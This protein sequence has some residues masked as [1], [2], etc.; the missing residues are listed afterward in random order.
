MSRRNDSKA[1]ALVAAMLALALAGAV[2][3]A[4]ARRSAERALEANT[5][6]ESLRIRWASLSCQRTLLSRAEGVLAEEEEK[7]RQPTSWCRRRLRLGGGLGVELVFGDEQAK[8]SVN[9]LYRRRGRAG[10]TAAL[11]KLTSGRR[12]A[13]RVALE[14][15]RFQPMLKD[16]KDET[17]DAFICFGQL[18]DPCRLEAL[19]GEAG[20]RGGDSPPAAAKI[21]CWG[22]GTLSFRRASRAAMAEVA[23]GAISGVH[24]AKLLQLRRAEPKVSLE[25]ALGRI[26]LTDDQRA[27]ASK[28]LTDQS[29]C[30][31]M[32]IV[33]DTGRRR[34]YRLAVADTASGQAAAV[35]VKTFTW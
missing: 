23:A 17:E 11:G 29:M 27:A 6:A 7:T 30:Y 9:T 24:Q 28:L 16:D 25:E 15:R 3:A 33:V 5:A 1:F 4:V 2:L 14:P 18:F 10:L 13:L 32:W 35:N 8:A 20:G 21:T 12:E 19:V 26:G 34:W 22:D 31:S